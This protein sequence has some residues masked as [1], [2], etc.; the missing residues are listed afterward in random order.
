M[1]AV[2]VAVSIENEAGARAELEE[3]VVPMVKQAPGFVS[4]VWLAPQDGR[5]Y[6]TA[7]FETEEQARAMA[8]G[9]QAPPDSA[10]RILHVG[11]QEVAA[12]A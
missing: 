6:S 11:V 1:H 8:D 3:R 7:V 10:V 4:G 12:Y 2:L 5:A 9:V